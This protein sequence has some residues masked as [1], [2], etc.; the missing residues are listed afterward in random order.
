MGS[1]YTPAEVY[2]K[3]NELLSQ[4]RRLALA[5]VIR[6]QG[7][8]PRGTSAKMIITADGEVYGTVG[9]GCVENYIMAEAQKVLEDG[10]MRIV[11]ADLGDD[12]WS[13][14]GMACGG[15]VELAIE[16]IEPEHRLVLLG[17]GHVAKAIAKLANMVG[18]SLV[19]I[20]P[21]AK[22]EDFPEAKI[23]LGEDY[24]KGL[25]KVPLFKHDNV[26][27]LTRHKADEDALRAVIDSKAEYIGM[28]GSKNRVRLVYEEL[29]KEGITAEKL[30]RVH[31]PIG[32]D[33]GAETP[34]EIAVSI[35]GEIIMF[36]RGG[37]GESMALTTL[38]QPEE[39]QTPAS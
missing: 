39:I 15:K 36:R 26:V 31:A 27:I 21:F 5:S 2:N 29:V 10:Q 33:I 7:S 14:I 32:L 19:V 3:I 4:G 18:L 8:T 9:G 22:P 6:A 38:K 34:E 16:L 1:L 37:K 24:A 12:S 23:V 17:A 20:D 28:I 13:G 11:E 30:L 35:I 25:Q